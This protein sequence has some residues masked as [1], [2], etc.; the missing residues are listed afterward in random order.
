MPEW[1]ALLR[2]ALADAGV[3][4]DTAVLLIVD[5]A[6]PPT[7]LE[8]AY[9]PP[10]DW[11]GLENRVLRDAGCQLFEFRS[12]HRFAVYGELTAAA[13]E[14]TA[15]VGLRHEAEHAAQFDRHGPKLTYLESIL[16]RAMARADRQRDYTRIPS[17]RAANRVAGAF[18][19]ARYPEAIPALAADVRFSQFVTPAAVTTNL[20]DE[21]T[22]MI[23]DY[24]D[25]DDIDDEDTRLRRP[26]RIVVPALRADALDWTPARPEGRVRRADHQPFVVLV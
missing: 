3:F 22:E 4:E 16:R 26:F 23:W 21:T 17:E 14:A 6:P 5:A 25:P 11:G 24:V 15:A 10:G 2:V 18:A 8:F 13:P 12:V 20:I 9:L 1:P 19:Q 7:A